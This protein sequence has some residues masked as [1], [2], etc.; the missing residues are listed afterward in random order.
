MLQDKLAILHEIESSLNILICGTDLS[1]IN[2]RGRIPVF[3]RG[4]NFIQVESED[5]T[6]HFDSVSYGEVKN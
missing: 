2:Y 3:V 5:M 6:L 4:R 1:K